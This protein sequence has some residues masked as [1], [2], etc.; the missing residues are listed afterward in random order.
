V[1][2][3]LG[4]AWE[5]LQHAEHNYDENYGTVF[6]NYA[7][8]VIKSRILWEAWDSSLI[9]IPST[10]R[11]EAYKYLFTGENIPD[12]A[13]DRVRQALKVMQFYYEWDYKED[14][15]ACYTLE[16]EEVDYREF[17]CFIKKI[18]FKAMDSLD[19]RSRK[20]VK[21]HHG[22]K[23]GRCYNFSEIAAMPIERKDGKDKRLTKQAV[24]ILYLNA[25]EKIRNHLLKKVKNGKLKLPS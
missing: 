20:I 1:E 10:A 16:L 15:F 14:N 2:D 25:I 8:R 13:P 24:R 7:L 23:D 17:C 22:F 11:I 21:L 4:I 19:S 9:R 6:S 18:L 5:A 12:N 3:Y